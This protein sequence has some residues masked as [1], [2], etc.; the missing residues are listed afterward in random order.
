[1]EQRW[2]A[3]DPR[4]SSWLRAGG[5][6]W[7]PAASAIRLR[8]TRR[9]ISLCGRCVCPSTVLL[10]WRCHFGPAVSAR[11]TLYWP[12]IA[13]GPLP[14]SRAQ[15]MPP[16]HALCTRVPCLNSHALSRSHHPDASSL[17][18]NY[19]HTP[20]YS[21]IIKASQ[22]AN[23]RSACRNVPPQRACRV[24][25]NHHYSGLSATPCA[26]QPKATVYVYQLVDDAVKV[27]KIDYQ[28]PGAPVTL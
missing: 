19:T 1:M 18:G 11:P 5:C 13:N 25:H 12:P 4:P 8:Q 7:T 24:T 27:E 16:A 20:W 22:H 9:C 21:H 3:H 2:A 17:P 28:K 14:R 15:P 26:P 23:I 6:C 10:S